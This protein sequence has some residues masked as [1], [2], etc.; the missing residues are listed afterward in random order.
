MLGEEKGKLM[1]MTKRTSLVLMVL[2][3]F[4]MGMGNERAIAAEIRPVETII[5]DVKKHIGELTINV[6]SI[7]KRIEFLQALP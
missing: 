4:L 3:L 7:K 5:N 6:E 2:T 1:R